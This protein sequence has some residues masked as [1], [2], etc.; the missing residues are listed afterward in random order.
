MTVFFGLVNVL[1]FPYFNRTNSYAVI[2]FK[3]TNSLY[4]HSVCLYR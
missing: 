2:A 4:W 1:G 3:C